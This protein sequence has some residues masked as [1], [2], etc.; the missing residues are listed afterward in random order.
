MHLTLQ[1]VPSIHAN[2][3]MHMYKNKHIMLT[4]GTAKAW[5]VKLIYSEGEYLLGNGWGEFVIDKQIQVND[6]V[7]FNMMK[8]KK[9]YAMVFTP[10]E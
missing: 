2:K 9:Y 7:V 8:P 10:D 1:E 5:F 3:H 6:I 4:T